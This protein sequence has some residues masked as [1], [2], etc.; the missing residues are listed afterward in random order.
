MREFLRIFMIYFLIQL[1]EAGN[2]TNFTRPCVYNASSTAAIPTTTFSIKSKSP[3]ASKMSP[4]ECS[5][6][7]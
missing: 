3:A 6:K 1:L 7:Q 2:I 5:S 4:D